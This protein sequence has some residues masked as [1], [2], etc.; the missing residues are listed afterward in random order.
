PNYHLSTI[1]TQQVT[2][3]KASRIASN[4]ELDG[5]MQLMLQNLGMM[6]TDWAFT[7]KQAIIQQINAVQNGRLTHYELFL[8]QPVHYTSEEMLNQALVQQGAVGLDPRYI[9]LTLAWALEPERFTV[10]TS[11]RPI[12]MVNLL[13]DGN[14]LVSVMNAMQIKPRLST[15]LTSDNPQTREI[16]AVLIGQTRD[17]NFSPALHKALLDKAPTVRQAAL[18]SLFQI[19]LDEALTIAAKRLNEPNQTLDTRF[20]LITSLGQ[21]QSLKAVPLLLERFQDPNEREEIRQAAATQLGNL[22]A[23]EAI[24]IFHA[25]LSNLNERLEARLGAIEGLTLLN[26]LTSIESLLKHLQDPEE[27][28][29]IRTAAASALGRLEV[30][31]AVP[32]LL[33]LLERSDTDENFK[34]SAISALSSMQHPSII[35]RLTA[36]LKTLPATSNVAMQLEVMLKNLVIPQHGIEAATQLSN[37]HKQFLVQMS[38]QAS[39]PFYQPAHSTLSV[40]SNLVNLITGTYDQRQALMTAWAI[41]DQNRNSALLRIALDT[42]TTT[43]IR[44]QALLAIQATGSDQAVAAAL[45]PLTK[46]SASQIRVQSTEALLRLLEGEALLAW[47]SSSDIAVS[48][49]RTALARYVATSPRA[50]AIKHLIGFAQDANSPL[51]TEAYTQLAELKATEA[52]PVIKEGLANL[53]AAYRQWRKLRDQQPTDLSDPAAYTD[54]QARFAAAQPKQAGLAFYYGYALAQMGFEQ[55]LI[56]LNHDLA[57]VR[58]GASISWGKYATVANLQALAQERLQRPEQPLFQQASYMALNQALLSLELST[59]SKEIKALEIWQTQAQEH[60]TDP[61]SQRLAWTI[62]MIKHYQQLD[63]L[64]ATKYQL[65]RKS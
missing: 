20:L 58:L 43:S 18:R 10:Q 4:P 29:D 11:I 15:A 36:Y 38:T 19:N 62:R 37:T 50:T 24:P 49:L 57:D 2:D 22:G 21:S 28:I 27:R 52:L 12:E 59:D 63:Q 45:L 7:Q 5:M 3:A 14:L 55:A 25:V 48:T 35:P 1:Q 39:T 64:F 32:I 30:Q 40:D 33:D 17:A 46:D 8:D 16:A 65:K 41:Q 23:T 51:Q 34:Y 31:A 9:E 53:E 56:A 13:L 42:H 61:I 44:A 54:W 47:L 6:K 26:D 60:S